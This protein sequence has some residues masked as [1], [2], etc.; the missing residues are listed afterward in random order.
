MEFG[1]DTSFPSEGLRRWS[2]DGDVATSLDG[3]PGV[4]VG[5]LLL[6]VAMAVG[7]VAVY[8][9]VYVTSAEWAL[10]V[11]NLILGGF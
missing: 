1:S 6:N 7:G 9:V 10:L 11:G 4:V 3:A 5:L 8:S 2:A